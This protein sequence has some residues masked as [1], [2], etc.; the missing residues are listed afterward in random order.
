MRAYRLELLRHESGKYKM[1]RSSQQIR[2]SKLL[3]ERFRKIHGLKITDVEIAARLG[4]A[5]ITISRMRKELKLAKVSFHRELRSHIHRHK[6]WLIANHDKLTEE[7]ICKH[8]GLKHPG[9]L[10]HWRKKLGLYKGHKGKW[11]R[12]PHPR[13][14]LNHRHSAET[15]AQQKV[16]SKARWLNKEFRDLQDSH[17]QEKGLK[18]A[19]IN[20]NRLK[21]N[22]ASI[23]SRAKQGYRS[24]LNNQY[25]RSS[26]EANYAR[27]L[28]L[29]I[30]KAEI[31]KWEYEAETF[32]FY[33]IKRGVRSYTP[34]FKIWDSKIENPYFV[35]VKGWMDPKS[36]TKL[37][38]MRIYYPD[39]RIDVVG[40]KEYRGLK[41]FASMIPGWEF[42][43]SDL[44]RITPLSMGPKN[45]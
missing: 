4:I 40:E 31:V 24:D 16:E 25:F 1:P 43:K 41:Q 38:R 22:P 2:E 11:T 19:K 42:E 29:L 7:E 26:M 36:I 27:Y 39:I 10:A 18:L 44:R 20:I 14:F 13:G 21:K 32:W 23:Y 35:E 30:S 33:E 37:K 5:Q 28:N 8:V 6:N 17:V 15:K 45:G 3:R 34:D 9:S 12:H